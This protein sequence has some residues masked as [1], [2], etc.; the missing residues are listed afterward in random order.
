M[1]DDSVFCVFLLEFQDMQP[2]KRQQPRL[3]GG[4]YAALDVANASTTAL[5]ACAE[6]S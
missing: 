3:Q 1:L 5:A 4:D 6:Q 2:S